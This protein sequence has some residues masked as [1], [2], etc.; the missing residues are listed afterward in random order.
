[1]KSLLL[2]S[3]CVVLLTACG[4][5]ATGTAT[6][7]ATDLPTF[8]QV[9]LPTS[10]ITES[11][12][13]TP[14]GLKYCVVPA[15]LNL[16]S[17]PGIQYSIVAIEAQGICGQVTARNED[18][19]WAYMSTGKYTGWAYVKYL[20]GTGDISALPVFKQLTPTP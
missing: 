4:V 15:L 9:Q 19:S 3:I 8:T 11:P 17:G 10:T 7:T 6:P 18:A 5:S 16:R 1:M 2:S 20:S 13:I 14:A 12:S